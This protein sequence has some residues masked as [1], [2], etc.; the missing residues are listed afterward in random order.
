MQKFQ[1]RISSNDMETLLAAVSLRSLRMVAKH[2]LSRM[3]TSTTTMRPRLESK[4]IHPKMLLGKCRA[5]CVMYLDPAV[6]TL[7]LQAP[8]IKLGWILVHLLLLNRPIDESAVLAMVASQAQKFNRRAFLIDPVQ[9]LVPWA[10][11][12]K[13]CFVLSQFISFLFMHIRTIAIPLFDDF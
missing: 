3:L 1:P 9:V 7:I 8:S 6:A 2:S 10:L 5:R 13:I 4:Q 12:D 11:L